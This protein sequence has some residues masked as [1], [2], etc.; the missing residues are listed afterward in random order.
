M[1]DGGELAATGGQIGPADP[2]ADPWAPLRRLTPARI[3]LGRVGT[4]PSL[5]SVLD[6]RVAHAEARD[7]VWTEPDWPAIEG[8]L[9]GA[10][11]PW[12]SAH[13]RVPSREAYLLRPDLGRELD[14][15]SRTA[16]AAQ[17]AD[18]DIVVCLV[19]GLSGTA[20]SRHGV[21]FLS[22]LLPLF[23]DA[24]WRLAPVVLARQGRVALG[25]AIAE[26]VG[27]RMALVVIGE[28]PGLSAADSLGLYL[29]YD[30]RPG[31]LDSERNCISNVRPGGLPPTAAAE[32]AAAYAVAARQQARTGTG[33][34]DGYRS[35]ARST[36]TD[37][38]ATARTSP[39]V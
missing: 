9:T 36:T 4:A 37:R 38:A 2:P 8:E 7:A 11:V 22:A 16:L 31:R 6:L 13:S 17:R 14:D 28:R 1:T 32:L 19:D 35:N 25:D 18:V 12:L 24:N 5:A 27:A 34:V 39:P 20:L 21:P 29:T 15:P 23:R 26:A 3:G 10:D 30:A 33:I